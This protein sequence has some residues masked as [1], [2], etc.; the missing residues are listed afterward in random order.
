M[1]EPNVNDNG[2]GTGTGTAENMISKADSDALVLKA[3]NDAKAEFE[4]SLNDAKA[5]ARTEEKDKLY[6]EITKLKTD[7][8]AADAKVTELTN[9]VTELNTKVTELTA[10]L[11]A[12]EKEL[13]DM[14]ETGTKN[15]EYEKEI[16]ELREGL[17]KITN[18]FN[19]NQKE[20]EKMQKAKEVAD[21]RAEKLKELPDP[22]FHALVTGSTKEE[23]EASF[24][25]VKAAYDKVAEKLNVRMPAAP[26]I[27]AAVLD[28]S[29]LFKNMTPLDITT[30]SD[31][32]W[33]ETRAQLV[34]Q[35]LLKA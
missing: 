28:Q 21:F 4:K 31:K 30:S 2:Q 3:V 14:S 1:A 34:K 7:K 9:S 32:S 35:G 10:K 29:E 16:G 8:E 11:E 20:I 5:A 12:K 23:I 25:N 27:P 13:A 15:A 33:A 6:P 17:V 18:A 22:D 26:K 24:V 19:A